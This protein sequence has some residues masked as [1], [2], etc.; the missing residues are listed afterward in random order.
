MTTTERP[1]TTR[2]RPQFHPLTVAKVEQLT[3][4]AI[5]NDF[6]RIRDESRTNTAVVD[7]TSGEQTEINERGPAASPEEVQRL[8]ERI[9]YLA[10]GTKLCVLAGSVPPG[11]GGAAG[12]ER[13]DMSL[14]SSARRWRP[15]RR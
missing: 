4:E 7:P 12:A 2:R 5:L 1:A 10:G 13:S 6:V 11:A 15:R 8:F 9:A 14:P 3:E